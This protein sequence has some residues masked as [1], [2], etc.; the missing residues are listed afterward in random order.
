MTHLLLWMHCIDLETALTSRVFNERSITFMQKRAKFSRTSPGGLRYWQ[1]WKSLVAALIWLLCAPV[2]VLLHHGASA[3][4]FSKMPGSV[5]ADWK[6]FREVVSGHLQDWIVSGKGP[7]FT[8]IYSEP[9]PAFTEEEYRAL[10]SRVF[11]RLRSVELATRRLGYNGSVSDFVLHLDYSDAGPKATEMLNQD[12]ANLSQ[13]IYGTRIGARAIDLAQ[14]AAHPPASA[15]PSPTPANANQLNKWLLTSD[16]ALK[17]IYPETGSV[18]TLSGLLIAQRAGRYISSD[19]SI[20]VLVFDFKRPLGFDDIRSTRL[21]ALDS[22][23]ILGGVVNGDSSVAIVARARQSS[24]VDFPPLRVEDVLNV[25]TTKDSHWAQSYDRTFPG[26]GK[27]IGARNRGEDWAP[28]YLSAGL[29]DTEFG[30]LLNQADAILKSQSL[31]NTVA[32]EG[33]AVK[34]I[35]NQPYPEGVFR[36]LQASSLIFNFNT[37]GTGHWLDGSGTSTFAANRVGSF[38]VTYLPAT[39]G[40]TSTV[41]GTQGVAQA[42]KIYTAWFD[43]ARDKTL[44]RTVQY[45]TIYQLFQNHQLTGVVAYPDRQEVF[46]AIGTTLRSAAARQLQNCIDYLATKDARILPEIQQAY[47]QRSQETGLDLTSVKAPTSQQDWVARATKAAVAARYDGNLN[48]ETSARLVRDLAARAEQYDKIVPQINADI[49]RYNKLK[50]AFDEKYGQYRC[51]PFFS[52]YHKELS[53]CSRSVPVFEHSQDSPDDNYYDLP[54]RRSAQFESDKRERQALASKITSQKNALRLIESDVRAANSKIEALILPS[55][56]DQITLEVLKDAC[57]YFRTEFTDEVLQDFESNITK[58]TT[59]GAAFL[60]LRTPTIVMSNNSRGVDLERSFV[61][62]HDAERI[63]YGIQIDPALPKGQF[64]SSEN[65]LRMSPADI[66]HLDNIA[67]NMARVSGADAKTQVRAFK[68][69]TTGDARSNP[70]HLA[71]LGIPSSDIRVD[72]VEKTSVSFSNAAAGE[73]VVREIRIGR[74]ADDGHLYLAHTTDTGTVRTKVYGGYALPE[75]IDRGGDGGPSIQVQLD[76]SLSPR[77]VEAIVGNY[78]SAGPATQAGGP[79]ASA[80]CAPGRDARTTCPRN[81]PSTPPPRVARAERPTEPRRCRRTRTSGR[82]STHPHRR[83]DRRSVS[84]PTERSAGPGTGRRSRRCV[85][86]AGSSE[87]R[88]PSRE[89][90]TSARRL[91]TWPNP[92]ARWFPRASRTT[93]TAPST[94]IGSRRRRSPPTGPGRERSSTWWTTPSSPSAPSSSRR[95]RPNPAPRRARSATCTPPSWTRRGWRPS[96]AAPLAEPLGL[97]AAADSVATVLAVLGT[98]ERRGGG[99][100]FRLF[101]DNDP[102]DPGATS[103]SSSR[104]ASACPTSAT[105]ARTTSRRIARPTARSS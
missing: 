15:A 60:A 71:A 51:R 54:S 98:L 67:A 23:F 53:L 95:S 16:S 41:E 64:V 57:A 104:A 35:P 73:A 79:S 3:Q 38:S 10:F 97:V 77:D 11:R 18:D 70:D 21:F 13:E 66:D 12:L 20:V 84:D 14:L 44:T 72:G 37:V 17:F 1:Y 45:M 8:L 90:V 59:P 91:A 36:H 4:S 69:A 105:T 62:G 74:S 47:L 58:T 68:D 75:I 29:I 34:A 9:P 42:E 100:L 32:Y 43:G 52:K 94:A 89:R 88:E 2:V 22:D 102:G 55:Q 31:S 5:D 81:R 40:Q 76:A 33:Y 83:P 49:E 6:K 25:A 39:N 63:R 96:G 61:G 82:A 101:V 93:C 85:G 99:S 92:K 78:I 50:D 48:E 27:V 65:S 28:S 24:P 26:A 19:N 46:D 30:S 87:P 86:A 56:G 7:R 80:P 103:C